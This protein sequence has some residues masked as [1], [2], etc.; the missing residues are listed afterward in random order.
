MN[1][2]RRIRK[3]ASPPPSPLLHISILL[4]IFSETHTLV[5]LNIFQDF[6]FSIK[7]GN[8]FSNTSILPKWKQKV[9]WLLDRTRG[10]SWF[11]FDMI[12]LIAGYNTFFLVFIPNICI[13]SL[14]ILFFFFSLS[15]S[16]IGLIW[17][18]SVIL[19][20]E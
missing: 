15:F 6:F 17:D 9:E 7:F 13:S 1:F 10:M 4:I 18:W 5:V 8:L 19:G 16:C 14:R 20:S 11:A 12:L 3:N 2:G